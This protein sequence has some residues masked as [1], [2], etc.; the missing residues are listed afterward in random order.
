MPLGN[1]VAKNSYQGSLY[2][3][4]FP[5][6][7]GVADQL[8]KLHGLCS[9]HE[10]KA[11]TTSAGGL[12]GNAHHYLKDMNAILY[13]TFH[14]VEELDKKISDAR[15]KY[16]H[17][18]N[19][20]KHINKVSELRDKLCATIMQSV[21]SFGHTATCRGEGWN[22]VLKGRGQ[23]K[24]YIAQANLMTLF[25]LIDRFAR[26]QDRRAL[27]VLI[28]LRRSGKRWTDYYQG[29]LDI[30]ERMAGRITCTLA[31]EGIPN[32]FTATDIDGK[33]STVNL[34]TPVIHRGIKYVI[35]TC[36]CGEYMSWF[37]MCGCIVRACNVAGVE[38]KVVTNIHPVHLPQHHP[39][40]PNA[41]R[42]CNMEDY[43]DIPQVL[44]SAQSSDLGSR[45]TTRGNS[46]DGTVLPTAFYNKFDRKMPTKRSE[47]IVELR[48]LF[49][50]VADFAINKGD[51]DTFKI[52]HCRLTQAK[53][54]VKRHVDE[55]TGE[56]LFYDAPQLPKH[57]S[58]KSDLVNGAKL[59]PKKMQK[60]ESWFGKLK[61]EEL[62]ALCK[63]AKV[64]VGGTNGDRI[65]RLRAERYVDE[66]GMKA[67]E[68]L[69]VLCSER[70]LPQWGTKYELVMRLLQVM[71]KGGTTL[72]TAPAKSGTENQ[73]LTTPV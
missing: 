30:A 17:N 1:L 18:A 49:N 56:G 38:Y 60:L 46:T 52:L 44:P 15:T 63:A 32:V 45:T 7:A 33:T 70:S 41:L 16:G 43:N 51:A 27:Q 19:S 42:A 9:W 25:N 36:T 65:E 28:S 29:R 31:T 67:S 37:M 68:E 58:D 3:D 73:V 50:E 61:G 59:P 48:K 39:M 55:D 12:N 4:N 5:G 14:T 24:E 2:T 6:S 26:E 21:F 69:A 10:S 34:S 54:E 64:K 47:Q 11:F 57:R 23:L 20:L 13:E 40:W 22:S 72:P 35:P 8:G 71:G 62:K 66:L 53:H